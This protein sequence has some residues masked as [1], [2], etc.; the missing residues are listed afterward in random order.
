MTKKEMQNISEEITYISERL[1]ILSPTNSIEGKQIKRFLNRLD[2]LEYKIDCFLL[3]EKKIPKLKL[4][5][6]S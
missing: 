3:S 4:V 1:N 5:S 2:F 6:S